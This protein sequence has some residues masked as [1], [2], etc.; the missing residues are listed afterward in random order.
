VRW[1]RI[2][3]LHIN[4]MGFI[5]QTWTLTKKNLR[6]AVLRNWL[7]TFLR[8]FL[9]PIVFVATPYLLI[10]R[11]LMPPPDILRVLH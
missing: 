11:M 8:A 10:L 2:L 7:S 3:L 5:R 9:L 4:Q 1:I 6:I